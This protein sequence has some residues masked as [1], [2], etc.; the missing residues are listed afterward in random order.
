MKPHDDS[1][2]TARIVIYRD[3]KTAERAAAGEFMALRSRLDLVIDPR[4][5]KEWAF[6]PVD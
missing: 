3:E 5:H 1:R 4:I 2:E 6:F